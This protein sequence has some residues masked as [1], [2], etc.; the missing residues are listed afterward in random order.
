[1]KSEIHPFTN[2]EILTILRNCLSH[3]YLGGR[4]VSDF[5]NRKGCGICLVTAMNKIDCQLH[6]CVY[7][8]SIII[9]NHNVMKII[10]VDST[11]H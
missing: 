6:F 3:G 1:M 5:G 7:C 4:R 2:M 9:V 8:C 10:R 11:Q